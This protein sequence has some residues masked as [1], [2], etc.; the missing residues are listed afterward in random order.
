MTQMPPVAVAQTRPVLGDVR[1]NL[2]EHVTL[3]GLAAA[4]GAK[5][6][7]FPELSATGY[8]LARGA[9]LAF[10]TT[11]E[12]LGV[13]TAA[14]AATGTTLVVG[15]PVR[16]GERLFIGAFI[17][18][19]RGGVALYTKRRLGA[20]GASARQDGVVPPP[21]SRF[22]E[23]GS[24]DPLVDLQGCTAAVAVC[25]DVGD[26]SHVQRAAGRGARAYLA[27]MF[28]IPSEFDAD[29][30]RLRRYAQDH[31]LVVALANYG[32]AT[33]GLAS[34]GRSSIW[35]ESGRL[36]TQLPATGTGVAVA[37]SAKSGWRA[38]VI[39]RE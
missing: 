28:V 11:D 9:E 29:A 20:F 22:F 4:A 6:L 25:A 18:D 1:A 3:A 2:D 37:T 10:T 14:A 35:S 13:L 7:L 27:S 23:S 39:M 30:E 34:A 33:G 19:P 24:L 31:A 8:E 17:L 26:P 32:G 15:A 38:E 12:R 36:L 21:E 5:L 16:L